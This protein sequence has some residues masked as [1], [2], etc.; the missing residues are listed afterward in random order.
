MGG[1]EGTVPH[2]CENEPLLFSSSHCA[3]INPVKW[4]K[5]VRYS[6][7]PCWFFGYVSW[8][9]VEFHR[10]LFQLVCPSPDEKGGTGVSTHIQFM[11]MSSYWMQPLSSS[12]YKLK[13]NEQLGGER[14][15][16]GLSW[17][18]DLVLRMCTNTH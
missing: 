15:M 17:L 4:V 11:H 8:F 5:W 14:E 16:P 9:M 12:V 1:R 13:E 2:I 7:M 6:V 3:K 10:T 18:G